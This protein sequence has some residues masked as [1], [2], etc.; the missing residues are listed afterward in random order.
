MFGNVAFSHRR[1]TRLL[2]LPHCERPQGEPKKGPSGSYKQRYGE[3]GAPPPPTSHPLIVELSSL[4]PTPN[5]ISGARSPKGNVKVF[6]PTSKQTLLG[7]PPPPSPLD[8][9]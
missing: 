5:I 9:L 3:R 6:Y 7:P 8:G 1:E 2:L 4:P